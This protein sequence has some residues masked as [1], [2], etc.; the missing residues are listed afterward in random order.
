MELDFLIGYG[1][2][3]FSHIFQLTR[4]FQSKN[5]WIMT[6]RKEGSKSVFET[7]LQPV[8]LSFNGKLI[9]YIINIISCILEV[10]EPHLD[11]LVLPLLHLCILEHSLNATVHIYNV[12]GREGGR[13]PGKTKMDR[14]P[15]HETQATNFMSRTTSLGSGYEAMHCHRAT[16]LASGYQSMSRTSIDRNKL[17]HGNSHAAFV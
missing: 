11:S 6:K 17:C 15:L 16:S 5:Q 1:I 2:Q 10:A 12:N 9:Q 13:F 14:N 7:S 8:P 3:F 4:H